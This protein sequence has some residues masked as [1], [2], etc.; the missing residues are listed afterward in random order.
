[1]KAMGIRVW[2]VCFVTALAAAACAAEYPQKPVRLVVGYAPGGGSDLITRIVGKAL[3]DR[4]HQPV[5]VDNRVGADGSIAAAYVANATPDG[6][7]LLMVTNSHTMPPIGY[8]LPYDPLKSFSAVSLVDDKPMV[9]L[10]SPAV[11]VNS[12]KDLIALAKSKPGHLHYGTDGPA[13]DPAFFMAL[14]MQ[15]AGISMTNVNYKGGGQSQI[16]VASGE[17]QLVFGTISAAMELVK[18]G[19]LKPLAVTT[20]TRSTVLP[21]VPTLA[22]AASLPTFN[23][24]AWNGILAPARTPRT[25]IDRIRS[26]IVEITKTAD[27]RRTLA[28]QGIRPIAS[29]PEAFAAHLAEEVDKHKAF[30][31]T[32]GMK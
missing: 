14:F 13:T 11:P 6:Y 27:M 20:N 4:W 21:D 24:S 10:V 17:I 18:G 31:R 25:I 16:A 29:T 5:V 19:R 32:L 7:T 12:V 9:L 30:F 8:T 22:E 26:D 15:Q 2:L 23:E 1:M 28:A 3:S